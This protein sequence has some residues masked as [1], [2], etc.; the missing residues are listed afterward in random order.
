[1]VR[2]YLFVIAG[3]YPNPYPSQ[4]RLAEE[5]ACDVRSI[6]VYQKLAVAAGFLQVFPDE[7][8]KRSPL[9]RHRTNRYL[10]TMEEESSGV[11]EEDSSS[12]EPSVHYV[13][14]RLDAS[15]SSSAKKKAQPRPPSAGSNVI[16][17]TGRRDSSSEPSRPTKAPAKRK[18]AADL[19]TPGANYRGKRKTPARKERWQVLAEYFSHQWRDLI[20][21]P[22]NR[23][24]RD[25]RDVESK[26]QC[27]SYINSHFVND[28]D[29]QVLARI[30]E[31][32]RLVTQRHVRIKDGQS[33]WLAF[34]GAWGRK[35]TIDIYE[36]TRAVNEYVSPSE[37]AQ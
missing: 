21:H 36:G 5:L 31:F 33:A 11:L 26:G 25:V 17:M 15:H 6:G 10:I 28:S 37:R 1:M 29:E 34:T 9:G 27:K 13:N 14:L 32:M 7:G 23:D 2:R 4:E 24:L 16:P 20:A 18:E 35:R 19:L 30:D 22:E 8:T 12:Q 3:Y